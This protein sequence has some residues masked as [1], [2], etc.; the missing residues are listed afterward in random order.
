MQKHRFFQ[1]IIIIFFFLGISVPFAQ[2]DNLY[3]LY[4]DNDIVELENIYSAGTISDPLWAKFI[5]NMFE[6]N[7]ENALPVYMQIYEQTSDEQLKKVTLD[8]ISQY[9]YAKGFYETANRILNDKQFRQK[10]FS[11]KKESIKFGVQLGAYSTYQNA[12]DARKK[13]ENINNEIF[14]ISK[15]SNGR[16]LYR[17]VAGKFETQLE[18]ERL[19]NEMRQKF[20]YRGIILQY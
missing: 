6:E 12:L 19:K 13:F 14:I 11:I 3:K 1:N 15:N 2:N 4:A 8:R 7:M 9:Y 18:A 16:N 5:G 10:I 20:G 17:I